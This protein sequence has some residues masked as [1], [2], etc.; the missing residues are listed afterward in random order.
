MVLLALVL[1]VLLGALVW[2][3]VL[4]L[5]RAEKRHREAE[6][7][8]RESEE[9][10]RTL[11]ESLQHLVWTCRPDGWCDYLSRQWLD[12]TGRSDREQLGYGWMELLHPADR[13]RVQAEWAASTRRS[14]R[15]DMEFRIRRAD[16]V[17]RWFKTRA[18]PLRDASG[19]VVK[20]FGSN[21]D[22]EDYKLAQQKLRAQLEQL[23]LLDR[24][25]RA[26]G[27][28]R[29]LRS[30]FQTV[31]AGLE[32]D[33]S[34][35]FGCVFLHDATRHS[36]IVN[37]V[38]AASQDFV[39]QLTMPEGTRVE[40]DA[41]GLERSVSGQLVYEPDI[42]RARFPFPRRL[43]RAGLGSLVLAPLIVES[44]VFGVLVAARR[45]AGGFSG[46]D[47]EFLRQLSEHV[48]L[49]V[50]QAELYGVL[51]RAY[52][53]LRQT[54]EGLVQ[55]EPLRALSQ[56]VRAVP[57]DF[58]SVRPPPLR[59]LV[60]DDD[61]LLLVS[62]RETLESDGHTLVIA[63]GGQAGIAA[64]DEA[65]RQGKPF[66]ILITDLGMPNVDGRKVAAAAKAARHPIPVI[67]LTGWG[68][69][70]LEDD[71]TPPYVDRVLSKPTRLPELRKTLAELTAAAAEPQRRAS[72]ERR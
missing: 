30:I 20:W 28:R 29:D 17:Y 18:V 36:L 49:A 1:I 54:Q 15:F 22:V 53:D 50:S 31:L 41:N 27:A 57:A 63:D 25:T 47:N 52:E 71:A 64:L 67:M 72:D 62:L 42:V 5:Q 69:R 33:F 60:V 21:T 66:N 34:I 26:I 38:G 58:E 40:I 7:A 8:L 35:D 13:E 11:A 23:H 48:A 43:A 14:E 6:S 2:G 24:S 65:E 55:D 70:L 9:H 44:K 59:I 16:G 45:S 46:D 19:A 3:S 51:Q 32:Q 56:M 10:F 68:K 37:C 39:P 12:Y 61:P 4:R